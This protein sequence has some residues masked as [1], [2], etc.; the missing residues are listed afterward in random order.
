MMNIF[1]KNRKGFTLIELIIVIAIIGILAA[2]AIP[3]FV[4]IKDQAEAKV[5]LANATNI[6]TAF[7][8]FNTLNPSSKLAD[9]VTFEQ[10][11]TALE[12]IS[13]WPEN[14]TAD[15]AQK[16]WALITISNGVATVSQDS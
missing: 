4:K 9:N 10:V 12:G 1:N 16:A 15:D 7:N 5:T 14:M 6:M 2:I 11:Q 13:M 8:A 3:S